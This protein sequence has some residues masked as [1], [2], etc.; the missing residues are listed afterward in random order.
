M[1]SNSRITYDDINE[2]N[3]LG[4]FSDTQKEIAV[5]F[6]E[7]YKISK[8]NDG[9]YPQLTDTIIN[10]L[11]EI[12]LEQSS[13]YKDVLDCDDKELKK[14]FDDSQDKKILLNYCIDHAHILKD[15]IQAL[16]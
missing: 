11:E 4:Y 12:V 2:G 9:V 13:F 6:F 15:E 5:K 7:A 10:T 1:K 14:Y 8:N 3:L 16:F